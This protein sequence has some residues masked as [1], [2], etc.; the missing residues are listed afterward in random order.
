MSADHIMEIMLYKTNRDSRRCNVL[1]ACLL[2]W[3]F[4]SLEFHPIL[5]LG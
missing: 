4:C 2:S 3:L 5:L 1:S